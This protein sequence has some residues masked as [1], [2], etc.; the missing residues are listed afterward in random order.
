MKLALLI[1]LLAWNCFSVTT[2]YVDVV[3]GL[4][5]NA[6]TSTG[7]AWQHCPG[8]AN[9]TGSS[10][11]VPGTI[12][13]FKGGVTN[14]SACFPANGSNG[15]TYTSLQSW[16][17]DSQWLQPIFDDA[18]HND[19]VLTFNGCTNSVVANIAITNISLPASPGAG[20]AIVFAN[21]I[22]GAVSNCTLITG[23][24]HN[25]VCYLTGGTNGACPTIASNE[26]AVFNTGIE[27][28]GNYDLSGAVYSSISISNNIAHDPHLAIT[29]GNHAQ[30]LHIY[31]PYD[32]N[33]NPTAVAATNVSVHDNHCYGDW[34]SGDG[35]TTV[36]NAQIY[37]EDGVTG[38]Q[39]YNNV[40]EIDNTSNTGQYILPNGGVMFWLNTNASCWNNS[41]FYGGV[42][43][44]GV[45]SHN[46]IQAT[47]TSN[48]PVG[49]MNFSNNICVGADYL[50]TVAHLSGQPAPFNTFTS[51]Y[52]LFYQGASSVVNYDTTL[53]T[54]QADSGMDI[55]SISLSPLFVSALTPPFNLALAVNSPAIGTG[56]NLSSVFQNDILDNPRS[57]PWSMGAYQTAVVNL[58]IS[59]CGGSTN[60]IIISGGT[61]AIIQ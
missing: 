37:F 15:V 31:G 49:N 17:I 20:Q 11:L 36:A 34:S 30:W 18:N 53:A 41:F 10:T 58:I 6:G 43:G 45:G 25:I 14:T 57:V 32:T 8:F 47:M 28:A 51:D 13:V 3:S 55:H 21:S 59:G 2:N 50:M 5:S 40:L 26:F 33:H 44:T 52:N 9:W 39:F 42:Y 46:C 60:C 22:G 19:H 61:N 48:A 56:V 23:S 7:V 27:I 1:I 38:I 4:D 54:W 35:G 16:Y 12:V 29:G 24:P